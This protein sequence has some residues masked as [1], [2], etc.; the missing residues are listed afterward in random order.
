MEYRT[1][2]NTGL[3]VSAV[4]LGTVE[5]GLDYGFRGSPHYQRPDLQEAIRVVHRALERGI[6]LIDTARAYGTSEEVIGTAL[7]QISKRPFIAS[8]VMISAETLASRDSNRLRKEMVESIETSLKMLRVESLDVLQIHNAAPEIVHWQEVLECLHEAQRQGKFRFLGAS[9]YGEEHALIALE[10]GQFRTLQAPFSF[11]DRRLMPKVFPRAVKDGVGLLTRST[12]L[13]GVLTSQV[14]S[15]P[16]QLSSL[17][18]AA[19]SA[20]AKCQ[21]E[22]DDLSELALR[23]CTST[24]EVSSVIIGVRSVAELDSNLDDVEKGH[25]SSEAV[26]K[27]LAQTVKDPTLLDTQK[28]QPLI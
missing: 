15:I 13:R 18:D 5:L 19:L 9:C 22:V 4:T 24:P 14:N 28:W 1:L 10:S 16:S 11:L 17:K 2:G 21:D 25:L 7:A 12:F 26:A 6:N 27:L 20:L 8:K 23:F 3:S